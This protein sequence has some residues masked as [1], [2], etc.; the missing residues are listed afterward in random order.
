MN[1][2]VCGVVCVFVFAQACAGYTLV[3]PDAS[4][5]NLIEGKYVVSFY[6]NVSVSQRRVALDS[7]QKVL[8]FFFLPSSFFLQNF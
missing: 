7:L 4:P 3:V 8:S 2:L 1:S 5:E 6:N